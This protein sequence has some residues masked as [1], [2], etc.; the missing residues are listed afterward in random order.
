V[1][2]APGREAEGMGDGAIGWCHSHERIAGPRM[3]PSDASIP[4]V[5]VERCLGGSRLTADV[6]SRRQSPEPHEQHIRRPTGSPPRALYF[7][8]S[9]HCRGLA[10]WHAVYSMWNHPLG[11]VAEALTP[12]VPEG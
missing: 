2:G 1:D 10:L 4:S 9:R 6:G 12:G 7:V 8:R 11:R 5:V 3:T